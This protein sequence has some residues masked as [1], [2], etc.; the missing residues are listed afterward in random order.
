[1]FERARAHSNHFVEAERLRKI[2]GIVE[3]E[4]LPGRNRPRQDALSS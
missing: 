3:R 4:F 1:M 2:L